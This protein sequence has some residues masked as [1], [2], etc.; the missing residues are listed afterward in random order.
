MT[1]H[2]PGSRAVNDFGKE[3]EENIMSMKL[4]V[5][6]LPFT[7]TDNELREMFAEAGNVSSA[8]VITDRATGQSRGFGFV[9]METKLEG[10]KAISMFN[11]RTIEGRALTVNEAKPQVKGGFGG[12]GGG[13]RGGGRRGY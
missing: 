6:N 7:V 10:Q 11:S 1:L 9:E 2:F 13:G 8:K 3:D 4:Y 12:R 5:G